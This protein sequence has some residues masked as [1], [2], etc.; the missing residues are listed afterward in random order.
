MEN[1]YKFVSLA[2]V[3]GLICLTGCPGKKQVE[4]PPKQQPQKAEKKPMPEPT[5][6]KSKVPETPKTPAPEKKTETPAPAARNPALLNPALAN[7][8]APNQFKVKMTT[9]KGDFTIQ[10]NRDWAPNGADRFYNLVKIGFFTDVAFFRIINGFMAQ[11]GISGDPQ[12]SAKWRETKIPDDSV[13]ESN[14]RGKI[15]FATSGPNSRT[16]QLFIN[17]GDNSR[18]DRRG[19]SPIGEVIEGMDVVDSLY[20]GYGEGAPRGR[21]PS[22]GYIQ[23]QGNKY[24]KAQFPKLDYIKSAQVVE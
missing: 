13:V 12:V 1:R 14:K 19:F 2:I 9:T 22:Q 24:L 8:T 6:E 18:L 20:D 21:G 16:T 3:F 15:S 17:F 7:E 10:V 23:Q 11:F 4:S 5:P